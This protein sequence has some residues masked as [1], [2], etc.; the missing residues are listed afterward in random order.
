[1]SIDTKKKQIATP[2]TDAGA[3]PVQ[4]PRVKLL[5]LDGLRG[6]AALYVLLFHLYNPE[7][8]PAVIRHGLSC[9]R[10]GHYA[11]GVFIVLS[12]HSLIDFCC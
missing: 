1:M 3:T 8:L 9:L 5:F 11:V 6:L 7:G 10:F 4:T 2:V 12:G